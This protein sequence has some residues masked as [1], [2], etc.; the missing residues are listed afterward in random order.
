MSNRFN[1]PDMLKRNRARYC[2]TA[3][4]YAE[5][6][7]AIRMIEIEKESNEKMRKIERQ[8]RPRHRESLPDKVERFVEW[9]TGC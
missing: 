3:I 6:K 5:C 4:A 1:D 7:S 8:H 9:V 2:K